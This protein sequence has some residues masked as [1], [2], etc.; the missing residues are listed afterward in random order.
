MAHQG[1]SEYARAPSKKR[2]DGHVKGD[3]EEESESECSMSGSDDAQP[4]ARK[5]PKQSMYGEGAPTGK[6][7]AY[8]SM[9]GGSIF[10]LIPKPIYDY[11]P[12]TR[13]FFDT[14]RTF[15]EFGNF[16]RGEMRPQLMAGQPRQSEQPQTSTDDTLPLPS[17]S[18][19]IP[20]TA[21]APP[22]SPPPPPIPPPPK[23]PEAPKAKPPALPSYRTPTTKLESIPLPSPTDYLERVYQSGLLQGM[24]ERY[25]TAPSQPVVQP[26][27]TP[28]VKARRTA[29]VAAGNKASAKQNALLARR[30]KEE[31]YI[32]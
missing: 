24:K 7:T 3:H 22:P 11:S 1:A 2:D 4:V 15:H 13:L 20:P 5:R 14:N 28:F 19:S 16:A 18:P 27:A 21:S 25:D 26:K 12:Q 29:D 6:A 23:R 31:E 17:P 9:T 10:D 8:H 30:L 32:R